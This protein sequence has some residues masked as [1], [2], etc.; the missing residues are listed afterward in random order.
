[1]SRFPSSVLIIISFAET[2]SATPAFFAI[3]QMPESFAVLYSIPVPTIG[4]SVT[5]KGTA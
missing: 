4:E 1:M 2:F 5:S 3:T